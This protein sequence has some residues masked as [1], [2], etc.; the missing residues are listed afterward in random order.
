[1]NKNLKIASSKGSSIILK[2]F[3]FSLIALEDCGRG[4]R[5][6]VP[7]WK[8][9]RNLDDEFESVGNVAALNDLNRLMD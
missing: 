4:K 9:R 8:V 6:K 5:L 7:S 1:M 2:Y 3:C